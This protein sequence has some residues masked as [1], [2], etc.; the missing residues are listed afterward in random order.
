[1]WLNSYVTDLDLVE[2]RPYGCFENYTNWTIQ[3]STLRGN[4]DPPEFGESYNFNQR[5]SG[6]FVP[7]ISGKYTLGLTS[8]D[9]ARLYLSLD[10]SRE[11]KQLVAYLDRLSH[12]VKT[13]TSN[14]IHLEAS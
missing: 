3:E 13:Q 12:S 11:Q 1:M 7:P 9:R 8:D 6:F 10:A 14:P 2:R 5:Y 4:I